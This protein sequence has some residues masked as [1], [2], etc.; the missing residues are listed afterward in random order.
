LD[1]WL[2]FAVFFAIVESIITANIVW[3]AWK[4]P[5]QGQLNL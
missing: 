3:Y 4:W 5:R 2:T 1:K